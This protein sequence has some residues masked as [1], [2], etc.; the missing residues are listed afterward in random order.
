MGRSRF[1]CRAANLYKEHDSVGIRKTVEN[2]E[3]KIYYVTIKDFPV[4]GMKVNPCINPRM[5]TIR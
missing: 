4:Y 3:K 1:F 5:N 2:T